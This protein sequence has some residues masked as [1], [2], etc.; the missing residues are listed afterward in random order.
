MKTRCAKC[1]KLISYGQ[2]YCEDCA[3]KI[4]KEKK[5]NMN[6]KELDNLL[7]RKE[8]IATRKKILLR[9][10]GLCV[11]CFKNGVIEHRGLQVHHIVKRIDDMSL[12]YEP[13]NLVT[14]CRSCHEKLEK[15]PVDKQKALLGNF[16]KDISY[17][18]L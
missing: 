2:T 18:L 11:L 1:K 7:K 15:L 5:K 16:D 12:M 10:K 6:F 17:N 3:S 9:D 4:T 13:S 8:W 14:V